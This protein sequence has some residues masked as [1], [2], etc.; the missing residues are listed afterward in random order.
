MDEI[1]AIGM[2]LYPTQQASELAHKCSLQFRLAVEQPHPGEPVLDGF[3][4]GF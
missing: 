1:K 2:L 4:D 3:A